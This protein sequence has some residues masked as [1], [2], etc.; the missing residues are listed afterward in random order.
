MHRPRRGRK[1][2]TGAAPLSQPGGS[3]AGVPETPW[4][5]I[6]PSP[7]VVKSTV[8]KFL[9]RPGW[10]AAQPG[11]LL[12]S[13]RVACAAWPAVVAPVVRRGKRPGP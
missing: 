13:P 7:E 8:Y 5:K 10:W 2:Q 11:Q 4:L 6:I 9:D 3:G 1:E 12:E